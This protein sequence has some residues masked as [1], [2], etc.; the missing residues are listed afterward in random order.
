MR[1][2]QAWVISVLFIV[3][4][5]ACQNGVAGGVPLGEPFEIEPRSSRSLQDRDQ[6]IRISRTD[7]EIISCGMGEDISEDGGDLWVWI[8]GTLDGEEF[9]KETYGDTFRVGEYEVEVVSSDWDGG[10]TLQ[11]NQASE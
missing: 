8:S 3:L 11:V 1:Q 5:S 10:C 9:S 7:L 2:K 6:G 4:F